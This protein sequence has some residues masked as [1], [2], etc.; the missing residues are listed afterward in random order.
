MT[1]EPLWFLLMVEAIALLAVGTGYLA[2]RLRRKNRRVEEPQRPGYSGILEELERSIAAAEKRLKDYQQREEEFA[3]FLAG[4][5]E[6][7]HLD[8]MRNLLDGMRSEGSEPLD[9]ISRWIRDEFPDVAA[10]R[11]QGIEMHFAVRRGRE[12]DGDC[13]PP[14]GRACEVSGGEESLKKRGKVV[15]KECTDL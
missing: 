11:L 15:E 9:S 4:R 13:A 14:E 12:G 1:I 3:L 8:M 5:V 7:L 2:Y 10:E 6:E